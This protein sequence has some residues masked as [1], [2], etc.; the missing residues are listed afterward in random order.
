MNPF[1]ITKSRSRLRVA[2]KAVEEFAV[3]QRYDA[4]VDLWYTFLT[5]AKNIYTVLEQGAKDTPQSSQWFGAKKNERREDALLQYLFQARN[6]DEH[7]LSPVTRHQPGFT[8]IGGMG[9][10]SAVR[11]NGTFGVG[12][13]IEVASLDGQ[14]V[15]V[16]QMMPHA[17]LVTVYGRDKRAYPP[18][19]EH[20][21]KPLPSNLPFPVATLAVAYLESLI[22]EAEALAQARSE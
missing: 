3:C 7:G 12:K 4:F 19:T 11:L 21:G 20:K 9:G 1:A 8:V 6:D 22:A 14:P 16:L 10:S 18:P 2:K 15:H 5:A 13:T 17:Q